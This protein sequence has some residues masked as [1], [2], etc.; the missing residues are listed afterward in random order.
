MAG[1]LRRLLVVDHEGWTMHGML[2]AAGRLPAAL[3]VGMAP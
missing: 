1:G 2:H 3:P